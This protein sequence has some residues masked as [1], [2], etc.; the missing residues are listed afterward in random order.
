MHGVHI[1]LK[2]IQCLLQED[3]ID[4]EI[5]AHAVSACAPTIG[6]VAIRERVQRV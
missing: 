5:V 6:Y 4:K 1:D 3:P 2:D